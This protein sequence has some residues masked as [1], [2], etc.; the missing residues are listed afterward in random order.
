[1]QPLD[2]LLLAL[3]PTTLR[4]QFVVPFQEWR[5]EFTPSFLTTTSHDELMQELGRFV[6]HLQEHWFRNAIPWPHE[7]A[8]AT[9][10][11]LLNQTFGDNR[12]HEAGVFAAMRACRHGD[13]G[14]LRTILDTLTRALQQE[15]LTH[16]L[17]CRVLPMI[18][19]LSPRES[20]QLARAYRD[21]Y[22]VLAGLELDS[23][24]SIAIRWQQV[25]HQHA[26]AVL[27]TNNRGV[28]RR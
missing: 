26:H 12:H 19:R 16:Y 2:A 17:D 7:Q 15:A 13:H 6:S 3:A 5:E 21:Q 28:R 9:A 24:A 11:R 27:N 1:M 23:A 10:R 18:S 14:G 22:R 20:L 25:I 8:I 4:T